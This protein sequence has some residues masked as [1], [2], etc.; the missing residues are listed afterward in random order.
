M[1]GYGAAPGPGRAGQHGGAVQHTPDGTGIDIT[2]GRAPD[3]SV[4]ASVQDDGEGIAP[5]Q[6][7]R[8]TERFY[9][10][11]TSR[12]RARGGTGLGLAIVKHALA[13]H[14]GELLIESTPGQGAR[15]TCVF[16]AEAARH[17]HPRM[18]QQSA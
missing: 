17:G 7:P 9:R 15:F 8:L 4:R 14:G 16:P 6:I 10:V 2:W 11:E 12:S 3:G 5:E 13:R 1:A 18:A